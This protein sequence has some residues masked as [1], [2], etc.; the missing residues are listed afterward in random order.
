MES[1]QSL[2][3]DYKKQMERGAVPKAYR[4]LMEYLM[5][6][7]AN[8]QKKHPD[9]SL[10][11]SLYQGYMDMTYFAFTPKS[12]QQKKLKIAIVFVHESCRFEAWLAAYNKP[13]QATYWK[14]FK[15]SGWNPASLVPTIKGVDSILETILVD[16]PDF[17]DLNGLN[18]KIEQAALKWIK[19]VEAFLAK[20]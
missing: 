18:K 14:W 1:L 2:I 3:Q 10:S 9:Y 19:E 20:H 7:R 4:G 16:E 15:E 11:A 12:L 6:L 17:S 5:A 8:L 13:V